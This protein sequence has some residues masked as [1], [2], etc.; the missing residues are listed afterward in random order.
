MS[1]IF[2]EDGTLTLH[3]SKFEVLGAFH[4]S[5]QSSLSNLLE[6][7]R[8]ENPWNSSV[9]RGMRAPGTGIP[10]LIMLG[11]LRYR[12]GKDFAAIYGRNP[13]YVLRFKGEEFKS[14]LI[15]YS[16]NLPAALG[17]KVVF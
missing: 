12:G 14:W 17:A 13:A 8:V 10:Y 15:T 9:M 3:L 6:I 5:P 7:R 16:G 4:R 11:T 2:L 1:I